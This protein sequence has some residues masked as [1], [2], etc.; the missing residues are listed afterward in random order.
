M[1]VLVAN[2]AADRLAARRGILGGGDEILEQQ[3]SGG[4]SRQF[5]R[6]EQRHFAFELNA[7]QPRD[8]RGAEALGDLA[9]HRAPNDEACRTVR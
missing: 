1:S 9:D 7:Q 3:V 4:L 8:A 5:E 6:I 2:A